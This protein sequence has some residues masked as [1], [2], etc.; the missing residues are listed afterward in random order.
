MNKFEARQKLLEGK[1]IT[2]V[3]FFPDQYLELL[4]GIVMN[5]EGYAMTNAEYNP[6]GYSSP[7]GKAPVEGWDLYQPKESQR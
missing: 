6:F 2:H 4:N 1:R 7:A 3:H 5:G